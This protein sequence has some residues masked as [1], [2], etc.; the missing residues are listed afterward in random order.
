[1]EKFKKQKTFADK[2]EKKTTT[3]LLPQQIF[4]FECFFQKKKKIIFAPWWKNEMWNSFRRQKNFSTNLRVFR[5][6]LKVFSPHVSASCVP[7]SE[8]K[9]KNFPLRIPCNEAKV[10][11]KMLIFCLI[12]VANMKKFTVIY[13]SECER[14]LSGS[15]W[16]KLYQKS[17][18][19]I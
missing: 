14:A 1:M 5:L 11:L 7:F 4:K 8:N 18:R 16:G 15:W 3:Q 13:E 9:K 17:L 19:L 10:T 6:T 2:L 12:Y